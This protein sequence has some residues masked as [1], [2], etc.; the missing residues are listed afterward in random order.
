[1]QATL[2]NKKDNVDTKIDYRIETI[3]KLLARRDKVDYKVHAR[4]AKEWF[5]SRH[6]DYYLDY[7]VVRRKDIDK[8]VVSTHYVVVSIMPR[9]GTINF[10]IY[11]IGVDYD[12]DQLFIN[13]ANYIDLYGLNIDKIDRITDSGRE[14]LIMYTDDDTIRENI[15]TYHHD[16]V[17]D[18]YTIQL[19]NVSVGILGARYRVQGDVV[20]SLYHFSPRDNIF[21]WSMSE[22]RRYI[23][24]LTLDK[25]AA[26]LM[27]NGLSIDVV[28]ADN[29]RYMLVV[30]GGT[31]SSR[32]SKYSSRNRLRIAKLLGE[33][34]DINVSQ[35]SF[36]TNV[37][38]KDGK[39][40]ARVE[41]TSRAYYGNNIGDI[42]I[43]VRDV[44]NQQLFDTILN[45]IVEQFKL[46]KPID[47]VRY[48][49][50]HRVE[51]K[52]VIPAM[53]SYNPQ[54]KPLV[55][56]P[57]TLYISTHHT[58]VVD[59]NSVVTLIHREH[60]VRKIKFADNYV[61]S[62]EH[63]TTHRDEIA[64]RNR[65]VLSKIEPYRL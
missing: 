43:V 8:L 16:V 53:F 12:S 65:V 18:E 35:S 20:F 52:H 21:A 39:T 2:V 29:N 49:G 19:P 6:G 4:I 32:W 37:D 15:F 48:I 36:F 58:Y 28:R 23:N 22:I 27:D 1:M 60:G 9:R 55:L 17:T 3:A 50:N 30:R 54:I 5:M 25:I 45:D 13:R 10:K 42:Q 57:L 64:E 59:T 56:E 40:L 7:V 24:Y 11:V 31:D 33:Y 47:M 41:I 63:V 38:I 34:F 62:I 14:V 51:L 46:L 61:L 44:E 26:I